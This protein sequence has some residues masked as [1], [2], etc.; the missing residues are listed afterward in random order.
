MNT[1]RK[2]HVPPSKEYLIEQYCVQKKPMHV[3]AKQLGLAVG[4]IYNN[5]KKYEIPSRTRGDYEMSEA[6]RQAVRRAGMNRKG[7]PKS[8]ETKQKLSAAKK[9]V[10]RKPS[11][12]GG[13]KKKRSDGYIIVF[14]PTHPQA[15]KDGY[16]LEHLLVAEEMI[17]RPL[18]SGEVVHHINGIKDDNRPENLMVMT[19]GNHM[20]YHMLKKHGRSVD[21]S[22]FA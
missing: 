11:K 17:G 20:R 8:D 4:T 13:A 21:V 16:R 5:I 19:A 14:T 12:Y 3:I 1:E 9:G 10:F 2:K 7:C 22:T 15:T 18:V 6:H